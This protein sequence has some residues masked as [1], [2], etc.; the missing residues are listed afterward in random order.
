M[1]KYHFE[2]SLDSPIDVTNALRKAKLLEAPKIL[3]FGSAAASLL[4]ESA[5]LLSKMLDPATPFAEP[6]SWT[7]SGPTAA[8][9]TVM[10][11]G[12]SVSSDPQIPDTF[13][14]T[15]SLTEKSAIGGPK[16][17]SAIVEL[18][19]EL[20]PEIAIDH[21]KYAAL[22]CENARRLIHD[23]AQ[24]VQAIYS[25]GASLVHALSKDES[26]YPPK[27]ANWIRISNEQ[28]E[29][30]VNLIKEHRASYISPSAI[31]SPCRPCWAIAVLLAEFESH[32]FNK[33]S[34][35]SIGSIGG[36]CRAPLYR[37]LSDAGLVNV[38]LHK[39]LTCTAI[40]LSIL[41]E[42][43]LD[44]NENATLEFGFIPNPESSD[45]DNSKIYFGFTFPFGA[46]TRTKWQHPSFDP[47]RRDF[48]FGY[49][50]LLRG[51]EELGSIR[52]KFQGSNNEPAPEFIGVLLSQQAPA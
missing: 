49:L 1:Q 27:Q 36:K 37:P 2:I 33:G 29:R 35:G 32:Q 41:E 11:A 50:S 3:P 42:S 28:T 16:G 6:K 31:T 22:L 23:L 9:T 25:F 46:E 45:I 52:P 47:K 8:P 19:I 48:G 7:T 12:T 4:V 39:L 51:L 40:Y 44:L 43:T 10:S 30:L 17:A 15:A 26:V 13:L 14:V 24:P 5:E 18:K 21:K 34:K 20:N 38:D